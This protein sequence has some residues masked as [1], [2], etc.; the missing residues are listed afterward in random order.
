MPKTTKAQKEPKP[1]T[2]PKIKKLAANALKGPSTLI[3]N[4]TRGLA[5]SVMRHIETHD[6][7]L[8]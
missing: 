5:G 8:V 1:T 6:G 7:K 3:N 4:E 2:S